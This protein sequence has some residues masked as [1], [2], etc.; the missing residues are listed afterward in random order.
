MKPPNP[1]RRQA[2]EAGTHGNPRKLLAGRTKGAAP[3]IFVLATRTP[4]E[5][6]ARQDLVSPA[7]AKIYLGEGSGARL[8]ACRGLHRGPVSRDMA[9]R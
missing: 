2:L 9:L 1:N 8:W 3:A 4:L 5:L 7:T 6:E